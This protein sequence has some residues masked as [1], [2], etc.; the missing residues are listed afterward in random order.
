MHVADLRVDFWAAVA[1][2]GP[3]IGLTHSL[4]T[5]GLYNATSRMY[6]KLG[7]DLGGAG[8]A[9]RELRNHLA[10]LSNVSMGCLGA[11]GVV[12]MWALVA[13]GFSAES[14]VLD[15]VI[16]RIVVVGVLGTAMAGAA[17]LGVLL[18]RAAPDV[19]EYSVGNAYDTPPNGLG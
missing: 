17:V 1:A 11:C 2:I 10:L 6:R 14:D 12:M 3:V 7:R 18:A 13:L 5:S 15:S 4:I 9:A 8:S 16:A 19:A